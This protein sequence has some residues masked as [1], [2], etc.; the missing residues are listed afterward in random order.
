MYL[1][2]EKQ[3]ELHIASD[4]AIFFS[5]EPGMAF[6]KKSRIAGKTQFETIKSH[7]QRK[8]G[9]AKRLGS[10]DFL[11]FFSIKNQADKIN[12]GDINKISR[13]FTIEIDHPPCFWPREALKTTK[14]NGNFSGLKQFFLKELV[15]R[16]FSEAKVP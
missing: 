6:K 15:H 1:V 16:F 13:L 11:Y 4:S 9:G 14:N 8:P 5:P 7:C 2:G 10:A 12:F 3:I